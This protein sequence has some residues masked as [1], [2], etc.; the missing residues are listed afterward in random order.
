MSALHH[1]DAG[2]VPHVAQLG[3]INFFLAID[4]PGS[5]TDGIG[6]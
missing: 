6:I 1:Q 5:E 4:L 2:S 3:P